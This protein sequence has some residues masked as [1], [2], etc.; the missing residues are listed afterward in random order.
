MLGPLT[1][2]VQG[3]EEWMVGKISQKLE[4]GEAHLACDI[5]DTL[6]DIS[7]PSCLSNKTATSL[8]RCDNPKEK[9]DARLKQHQ[10]H[11]K[12]CL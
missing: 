5:G 12:K 9:K 1:Q 11:H 10:H 7:I 6:V 4:K 2:L 3:M 8:D